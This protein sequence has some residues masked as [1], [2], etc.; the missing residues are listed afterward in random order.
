VAF[1]APANLD[2]A[3]LARALGATATVTEATPGRY[4][5]E[6][7]G[8]GPAVTAAIATHLAEHGAALTDLVVGQTIEDV[9]FAAV[10]AAA[11]EHV[12]DDPEHTPSATGSST[13][14]GTGRR[15]R[16]TRRPRP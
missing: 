8:P 2:T 12:D 4:R 14:A 6:A 16:R 10:G 13:G 1:G 15:R 7:A 11:A 9:Y 3:A 5:V